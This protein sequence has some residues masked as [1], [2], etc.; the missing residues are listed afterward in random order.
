VNVL[1]E[2]V[3]EGDRQ[4]LQRWRVPFRQIGYQ[5]GR[6]GMS[7]EEVIPLLLTLH[8]PTFFTLDYGFYRRTL[9]M[10]DIV[11]SSWMC[12]SQRLP[13]SSAG[14]W[15]TSPSG[16]RLSAWKRSCGCRT[17]VFLSGGCMSS[18]RYTLTGSH[19]ALR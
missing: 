3:L 14:S 10:L 18:K 16:P 12:R 5:V 6:K 15:H 13:F 2:N 8:R 4:L 19:L 7:D 9:G 11:W 17:S 1:D